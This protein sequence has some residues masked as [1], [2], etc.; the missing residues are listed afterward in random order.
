MDDMKRKLPQFEPNPHLWTRIEGRMLRLASD[1]MHPIL[2]W[3][4]TAVVAGMLLLSISRPAINQDQ[5]V[6]PYPSH[7]ILYYE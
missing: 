7:K 1:T 4:L 5:D 2:G 3:S 6:N